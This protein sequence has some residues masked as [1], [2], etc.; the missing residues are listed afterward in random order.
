MQI[1]VIHFSRFRDA[2]TDGA[3]PLVSEFDDEFRAHKAPPPVVEAVS[4]HPHL[5]EAGRCLVAEWAWDPTIGE[6]GNYRQIAVTNVASIDTA[7]QYIPGGF[8]R[9]M[10]P[11]A[12][13][14]EAWVLL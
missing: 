3:I 6:G 11:L 4:I 12:F 9:L 10:V 13:G 1:E 5:L 7:H 2:L 8:T 14:L